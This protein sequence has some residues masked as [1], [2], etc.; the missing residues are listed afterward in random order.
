M[1]FVNR[2]D[3]MPEHHLSG[4]EWEQ[5]SCQRE[6]ETSGDRCPHVC[7]SLQA[8]AARA[9]PLEKADGRWTA[10]ACRARGSLL[11]PPAAAAAVAH[12]LC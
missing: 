4:R 8:L 2:S 10:A 12:S 3:R 11:Q 7:R 6:A 9:W 5:T 1:L